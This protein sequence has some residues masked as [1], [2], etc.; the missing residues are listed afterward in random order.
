MCVLAEVFTPIAS[1]ALKPLGAQTWNIRRS[2]V[3]LATQIQHANIYLAL[4]PLFSVKLVG[5]MVDE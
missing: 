4:M 3:L 5:N 1:I 2:F